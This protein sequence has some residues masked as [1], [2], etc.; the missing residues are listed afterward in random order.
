MKV[1]FPGSFDPPTLGHLN[2]IERAANLFDEV[3][4]AVGVDTEKA[5]AVFTIE[6]RLAFLEGQFEAYKNV[7]PIADGAG[8]RS[9]LDHA[10]HKT[11]FDELPEATSWREYV[12]TLRGE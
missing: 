2:I 6:E 12:D 4:V 10:L 5:P 3:V 1:I 8:G 7:M 9:I 11:A